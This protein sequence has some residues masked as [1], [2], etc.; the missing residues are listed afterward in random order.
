[1]A[2]P[3][4]QPETTDRLV[5]LLVDDD[6]IFRSIAEAHFIQAGFAVVAAG[7]ALQALD[8]VE[9][10]TALDCV[11]SDIW[12]PTGTPHG[13]SLASMVNIRFP[14]VL[15]IFVTGDPDAKN[16]VTPSE[17]T[18]FTKPV[19]LAAVTEKIHALRRDATE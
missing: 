8:A 12:L 10:L 6:E 18:V 13:V 11:V 14:G 19:D 16:Y 4:Q 9:Q 2:A 15:R 5:M 7:D 1:M 3:E 17:G